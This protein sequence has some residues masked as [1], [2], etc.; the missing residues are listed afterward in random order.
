MTWDG[1]CF[2]VRPAEGNC[3]VLPASRTYTL[4]FC[5]VGPGEALRLL[6]NGQPAE[7][8]VSYDGQR[9]SLTLR[10]PAVTP[11]DRLEVRFGRV[12][13]VCSNDLAGQL[14][15]LLYKA[16]ME[17]EKKERIYAYAREGRRPLELLGL[18][19]TM[20]LS[21]AVCGMLSEVLLAEVG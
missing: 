3:A 14:F 5:G 12:L 17:Y 15:Q 2:A 10:A 18:L 20:D 7:A 9:H 11:A 16:E 13:P 21:P 4:E 8:A 6:V 19:Q 1:A